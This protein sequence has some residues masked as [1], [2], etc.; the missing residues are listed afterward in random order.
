MPDSVE[1]DRRE[2][3]LTRSLFALFYAMEGN[4]TPEVIDTNE[5]VLAL[6][7]K[8]GNLSQLVGP[9]VVRGTSA[10]GSGDVLAASAFGDQALKL[11]LREGSPGSLGLA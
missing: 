11:A 10:L 8:T 9:V 2:L 6:A 1:R 5:R 4:S 7:E 3:D